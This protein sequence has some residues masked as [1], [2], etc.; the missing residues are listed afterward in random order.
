MH[1][2]PHLEQRLVLLLPQRLQLLLVL[3]PEA[4]HHL[5]PLR[6]GVARPRLLARLLRRAR[7]VTHLPGGLARRGPGRGVGGGPVVEGLLLQSDTVNTVTMDRE[8]SQL[9]LLHP[10]MVKSVRKIK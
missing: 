8:Q 4:E 10:A 5:L 6:L 3:A 7:A 2:V 1:S 9:T